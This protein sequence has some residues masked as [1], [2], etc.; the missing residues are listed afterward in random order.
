MTLEEA[1]M[2]LPG[3]TGTIYTILGENDIDE[4]LVKVSSDAQ[5]YRVYVHKSTWKQ[6]DEIESPRS[7]GTYANL[8]GVHECLARQSFKIDPNGWEIDNT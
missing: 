6:A 3:K 4:M 7:L 5:Q 8:E 1:V 2:H